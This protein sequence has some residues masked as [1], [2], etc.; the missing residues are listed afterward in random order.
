MADL[1]RAMEIAVAAHKGQRQKNGQPY[2]L[3]PLGLMFA[4]T[5]ADAKIA[6]VLHDVVED[7][8]WTLA[9]LRAEGF[10]PQVV[11]ALDCLTHREGEAYQDYIDRIATNR[12][13]RQVKL[14]DLVDNMNLLRLPTF[15]DQDAVR[16][17]KY[18]AAWRRLSEG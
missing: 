16:L 5:T 1:Q 3:H 18:H 6:A 12:V 9:D 11:D 2:V 10:S 13:A 4:V 8:H 7:S 14:A 17:A 15:A